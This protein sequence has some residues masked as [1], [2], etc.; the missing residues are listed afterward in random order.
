M[1]TAKR[2]QEAQRAIEPA[3]DVNDIVDEMILRA[4]KIV[5]KGVRFLDLVDDD[6]RLRA[7]IGAPIVSVMTTVMEEAYVPPTPPA[8]TTSFARSLSPAG[9]RPADSDVA[10]DA[11]ASSAASDVAQTMFPLNKRL[12]S[13]HSPGTNTHHRL[14]YSS[15]LPGKR[16]SAISHRVSLAGPSP[17]SR[18]QNLVSE[19]L[20]SCLDIFLSHLGSFIGR[21]QVQ[22]QSRPQLALSV[23]QSVSSG[24]DLL[25]VVDV[26][27][28]QNSATSDAI[29]H[30]R[31]AMYDRIQDLA[32]TARDII[33]HSAPELEDVIVPQDNHRLLMAATG[34]VKATGECVAMAKWVIERIGDFEFD[35]DD[36]QVKIDLNLD[37]SAFDFHVER[38]KASNAAEAASIA[39]SSVS[40]APTTS[41]TSTVSTAPPRLRVLSVDKPLPQVPQEESPID[42]VSPSSQ[43]PSRP[44]SHTADDTAAAL[45][46]SLSSLRPTLPPL[47]RISTTLLPSD[48][49]SPTDTSANHESDFS[50]RVESLTATSSGSTS[51]YLSRDSES[52]LVS[53]TSTRATTPDNTDHIPA[54]KN[55]PSMSELSTAGSSA[56][57]VEEE[58]LES[59]LMEKTYAHELIFNKEG[60]VVGGSL[61]AL[62]ERLT[63][64]EATPDAMFVSTFYLTF[65]L[66]CTPTKLAEA[67]IDRFDYVGEAPHIASPVRLR[68]Y[69]VFKGWLES[70]W[71]EDTDCEA[72]DLIKSFADSK[73]TDI[74]PSAGRRLSELA[75]KVSSTDGALVPRLVSSMGKTNTS[76]SQYI[77]ADTPL[78]TPILSRSQTNALTNWKVGG[79]SPVILDFDPLEIARQLTIKQM[80][81]FCSI[82]PD[83][84]L[85]SKWTKHGGAGS[86]N[87]K[88]MSTFT[89]SLSNLVADTILQYEEVKKRAT[90]IKHW[91]KIGNQCL[92][93]H[94][95]DALMAITC[96][97]DDTSIKR[98]RI[99]WDS[100]STK[101]KD[102]LKALQSVVEFN[103]NHKVLRARLQE[104]VPPCLPFLGILLTD[105]TFIDVGNPPTR[106]ND[107][108]LTV[109]NFDK[110]TRTAKCIGELQRFQIPYRLTEVPD[111]LEW[112]EVQLLRVRE[113]DQVANAQTSH[114]R[115]SLLLEPRETPQLRTPVEAPAASLA[116]AATTTGI[117]GWMRSN[118][119][120]HT[121][122]LAA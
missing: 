22:S 6:R 26:V 101:R 18:R 110:H 65:R 38:E 42:E 24:G 62:V 51:T 88:A 57:Q 69:N 63:T 99:T 1:K 90:T 61:Q 4:F 66:F 28:A 32:F 56:N 15:A 74:L 120:S 114:Y 87:V 113:K 43:P 7:P 82:M 5:T 36:D 119:T 47:P 23:R 109:I 77:P 83:E 111:L 107:N 95:Y 86:P 121:P 112:L 115:K 78:P 97:L 64:H 60:Q 16:L 67:L 108:G 94:N 59:K 79:S 8:E 27:R 52:S 48:D 50:F 20:T 13:L 19:R 37:L 102:M 93:L 9:F 85:G 58:E 89:T 44:P 31:A 91:I 76:I 3:A 68:T 100:V 103:Q 21:G 30:Y 122:G 80:A 81:M 40:E 70:H 34:C 17:L 73:L 14:S 35:F 54:P 25:V 29:D 45:A 49:Y 2:L 104:H 106:T 75:D 46:S 72:M 39:E 71:R 118:S 105:L 92:A 98:L 41:T 84:L 12:S 116:P 96:A 10:T 55:Q 11:D 53:Q 33:T 117:F